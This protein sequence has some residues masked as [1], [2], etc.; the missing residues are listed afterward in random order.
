V[1]AQAQGVA[2][3]ETIAVRF[4][5]L[6]V[7]ETPGTVYFDDIHASLAGDFDADFDVDATDYGL[8]KQGYGVDA[9]GDADGDAD[10]DGRDFLLWQRFFNPTVIVAGAVPEPASAALLAAGLALA[11]RERSKRRTR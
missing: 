9:T 3:A 7:D 8:W 5:C 1:F 2:P 11:A 6:L 10:S 4:F